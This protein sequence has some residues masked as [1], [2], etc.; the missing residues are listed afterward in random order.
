MTE[1]SL[2]T[3]F[4]APTSPVGRATLLDSGGTPL[5]LHVAAVVGA[6]VLFGGAGSRTSPII[7]VVAGCVTAGLFAVLAVEFW[8]AEQRAAAESHRDAVDA[9][10]SVVGS[11][12]DSLQ[13]WIE[14]HP[15]RR[16]AVRVNRAIDVLLANRP[17]GPVRS[18]QLLCELAADGD[19]SL[20]I[21][22]ADDCTHG[23]LSEA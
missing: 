6:T 18:H 17:G 16:S 3:R 7:G 20:I 11:A 13:P 2:A 15:R 21:D 5:W 1:H 8:R 9:V 12:A 4:N 22:I 14:E 19:W 10:R 23:R